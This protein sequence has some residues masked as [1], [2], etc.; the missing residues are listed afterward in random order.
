M[1]ASDFFKAHGEWKKTE[2]Q[3]SEKERYLWEPGDSP[4]GHRAWELA[5]PKG[6]SIHLPEDREIC[7]TLQRDGHIKISD[8]YGGSIELSRVD[9]LALAAWIKEMYAGEDPG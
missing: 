4:A 7:A 8:Y 5:E 9:A 3:F 6:P 2:P 1:N